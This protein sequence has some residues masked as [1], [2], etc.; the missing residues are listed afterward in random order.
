MQVNRKHTAIAVSTLL[1]LLALAGIAYR[2][3]D[4]P[5]AIGYANRYRPFF[6]NVGLRA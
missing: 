5:K 3:K 2:A 4:Y 6:W 1:S